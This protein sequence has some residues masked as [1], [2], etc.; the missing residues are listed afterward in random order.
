MHPQLVCIKLMKDLISGNICVLLNQSMVPISEMAERGSRS[1][2]KEYD[3]LNTK[4]IQRKS[5]LEKYREKNLHQAAVKNAGLPVPPEN[6]CLPCVSFSALQ[7]DR[8]M[9]RNG[10]ASFFLFSLWNSIMRQF[11]ACHRGKRNISLT[12]SPVWQG[13]ILSSPM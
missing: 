6:C 10:A 11:S 5:N 8:Q 1:Y 4:Q 3:Y 9:V 2:L 12:H 7:V 13:P